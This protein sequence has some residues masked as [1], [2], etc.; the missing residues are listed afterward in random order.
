MAQVLVDTSAVYA[1]VDRNDAYHRRAVSLL[2]SLPRRGIA[3]LLT[4]FIIAETAVQIS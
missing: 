4:N 2:R 3:P 1:L